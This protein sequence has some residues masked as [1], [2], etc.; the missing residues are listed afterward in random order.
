MSVY[1]DAI[2]VDD[3]LHNHKYLTKT[4]DI[5]QVKCLHLLKNVLIAMTFFTCS[6]LK[7]VSMSNQ[8]CKIRPETINI[9]SNEPLLYPYS[10]LVNKCR[11]SCNDINN[12][13][14]K[15]CVPDV[16]KTMNVKVFNI[17]SRINE[18][19]YVS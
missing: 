18:T 8:E 15:L 5:V 1:Y 17:L 10:V 13:Y 12:P 11:G 4:H 9:N 14:A 3:I 16:A 2:A 6:A 19:R 7:C